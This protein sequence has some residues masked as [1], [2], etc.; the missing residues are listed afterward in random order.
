M[1]DERTGGKLEIK[2]GGPDVRLGAFED[3]RLRSDVLNAIKTRGL[4]PAG[5]SELAWFKDKKNW[6]KPAAK[7]L[8]S[9][10]V[11][12]CFFFDA[13]DGVHVPYL[14]WQNGKFKSGSSKLASDIAGKQNWYADS[15]AVLLP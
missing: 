7:A 2:E 10:R 11:L 3:F 4:T 14:S 5:H 12:F 1:V 13:S 8:Q 9:K 15:R 6:K